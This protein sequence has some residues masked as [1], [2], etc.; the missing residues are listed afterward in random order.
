MKKRPM[1]A[2]LAVSICAAVAVLASQ[3]VLAD[4]EAGMNYF[5]AGKYVEAAAEFQ[6]LVDNAPEYD[7]GYF[8]LGYSFLKMNKPEDAV[9][10]FEKAIELNPDKFEYRHGLASAYAATKNQRKV[11]E[12]LTAAESVLPEANRYQFYSMRGFANASLRQWSDA[13]EDLEEARKIKPTANVL[14]QLG[15]A[16]FAMRYN[17]EA[18]AAFQESLRIDPNA[19][20]IYQLLAE[21]LMNMGAGEKDQAKKKAYYGDALTAARRYLSKKQGD[22]DAHNLVGRAALGA[23][24]Y[25]GAIAE[26]DAA[27]RLKPNYCFA[28]INKS[29]CYIALE[30]WTSAE[31]S[32]RQAEK[33][34]ARNQIVYDSLGFVLRKQKRLEDS[35]AMYRKA[36]EIKATPAVQR[37]IEEVQHN[38]QVRDDNLAAEA[39]EKRMAEEAAKAEEEFKA[40]Q[41][42]IEEWKKKTEDD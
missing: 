33:C 17:A 15:K 21:S 8:I 37:S 1:S 34:D 22:F 42:K 11:I 40:E 24:D 41:K 30:E 5:K 19:T 27:L 6:A 23:R 25:E 18:A 12:T 14:N 10:N 35:L 2:I 28:M 7:Y 36:Y 4:F 39:E 13:I 32:L 31:A 9:R 20:E 29:K 38:I 26:F 3:A 16:Y